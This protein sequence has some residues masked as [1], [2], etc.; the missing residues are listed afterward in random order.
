MS[1]TGRSETVKV[2]APTAYL[3][4]TYPADVNAAGGHAYRGDRLT[5][6][7]GIVRHFEVRFGANPRRIERACQMDS[8]SAASQS[9]TMRATISGLSR[10]SCSQNRTT[11]QPSSMRALVLRLSSSCLSHAPWR[12]QIGQP[13][14]IVADAAFLEPLKIELKVLTHPLKDLLGS[15]R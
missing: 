8:T 12:L 9:E 6:F 14:Q 4:A 3:R 5:F 11:T 7:F 2:L 13:C 1:D 10:I 15:E